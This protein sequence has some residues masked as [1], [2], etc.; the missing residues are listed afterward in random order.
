MFWI[1]DSA[2]PAA[3]LLPENATWLITYFILKDLSD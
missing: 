1:K 3:P 2:I